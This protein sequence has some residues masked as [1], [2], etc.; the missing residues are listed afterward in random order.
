M[1]AQFQRQLK[2]IE[3][4]ESL[5]TNPY[6]HYNEKQNL[7]HEKEVLHNIMNMPVIMLNKM[8]G[9]FSFKKYQELHNFS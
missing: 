6:T 8:N 2:R 5:Y 4:R 1:K 9:S 3:V 7:I